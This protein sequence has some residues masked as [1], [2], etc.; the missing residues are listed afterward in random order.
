MSN[1][2]KISKSESLTQKAFQFFN[3]GDEKN[4]EV[5]ARKALKLYPNNPG[6]LHFLGLIL[7][8]KKQTIE[9]LKLL[10]K[11][12]ALYPNDDV[13]HYNYGIVLKESGQFEKALKEQKK[14]LELQPNHVEY[15]NEI[16]LNYIG[17]EQYD[18]AE[19][20]LQHALSLDQNNPNTLTNISCVFREKHQTSKA[21]NAAKKAIDINPAIASAHMNLS[22]S[23]FQANQIREGI[24]ALR[25]AQ[26]LRESFSIRDQQGLLMSLLYSDD[27][28]NEEIFQEH[29]KLADGYF[30]SNTISTP[31]RTIRQESKIK[32]GFISSD[33]RNHA[34]N[35]FFSPLIENLNIQRFETYCYSGVKQEDDCTNYLKKH[36][37]H[38]RDVY[39]QNEN[40]IAKRII[41]DKIDILIDLSG[42]SRGNFLNVLSLKP[43]PIQMTTI[44]YP[45]STALDTIDYKITD[46][47]CDPIGTTENIHTEKLVYLNPSFL[48]YKPGVNLELPERNP[49][50][51]GTVRFGSFN[52]FRKLSPTILKVWASILQNTEN[53][54][55]LLK[56]NLPI[57]TLLESNI[58]KVFDTSGISKNRVIFHHLIKSSKHHLE[59]YNTIDIALD[60]YPY[61]GTTTTF[62]ALWMG[63]PVITLCGDNH[64]SRVSSSILNNLGYPELIANS[65]DHY[66]KIATDLAGDPAKTS[67]Y[68]HHLREQL[69]NSPLTNAHE[70]AQKF[71]LLLETA[72]QQYYTNL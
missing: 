31:S 25:D 12:N 51:N 16:G 60:S 1:Q 19:K 11:A 24:D 71:E 64:R 8:K 28:S 14:A 10:K 58:R 22:K 55:L 54:T 18:A 53:S 41:K 67:H 46:S 52:N 68:H 6:C 30:T 66:V 23:Y 29:K 32:L 49:D 69:L 45:F 15:L 38:W 62:E 26:A 47:I 39:D 5:Q 42:H 48:C 56:N 37:K 40:D 35:N 9:A 44:G 57:S 27:I 61:T 50:N 72:W 17:L 3:S 59:I 20:Y 63:V 36:A 34:V 2:A 7:H 33:F 4:A 13:F 43:A 65:T 70:Y 21:I